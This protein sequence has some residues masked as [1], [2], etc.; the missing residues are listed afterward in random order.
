MI[1]EKWLIYNNKENKTVY[2]IIKYKVN[3]GGFFFR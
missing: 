1:N 3:L 2:I